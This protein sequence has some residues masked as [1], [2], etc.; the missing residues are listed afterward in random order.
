MIKDNW[1]EK[2]KTIVFDDKISKNKKFEISNYGR[3]KQYSNSEVKLVKKTYI[4]GYQNLPLKQAVNGKQTSRYVH[5][6]V[7]EHFLEKPEDGYCVVH[8]NYDKTD[9]RTQNLKW[10]NKQGKIA[11]LDKN[12]RYKNS[13]RRTNTKLT[14][15]KVRLLKRKLNDPNRRTRLKMIAKQFGVSKMQL[16]RIKTGENWGSVTDY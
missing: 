6:L 14:E 9:N 2:W 11:H 7:A 8:L 12:P 10:V 4:N 13:I 16:H 3:I 1:K 15:A 5:R